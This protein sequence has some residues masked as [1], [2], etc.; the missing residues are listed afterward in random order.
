MEAAAAPPRPPPPLAH[1]HV[2]C[3]LKAIIAAEQGLQRG[4]NTKRST[5]LLRYY[6]LYD[7][8]HCPVYENASALNEPVL[9]TTENR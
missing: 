9:P 7:T 3:H 8:G 6:L 5:V 2:H 4:S 1:L